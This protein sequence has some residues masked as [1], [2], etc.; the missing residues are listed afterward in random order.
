MTIGS[1]LAPLMPLYCE[2][3]THAPSDPVPDEEPPE[4][5]RAIQLI[6]NLP[7]DPDLAPGWHAAL[8]ASASA[9]AALC[10]D[11]RAEPEGAWFDA[12]HS[13]SQG[14]IRKVTRRA[15][16]AH[17][18]A[19]QDFAGVGVVHG[20]THVRALVP[21]LVQELD[22]RVAKL[23]VGGTDFPVNDQSVVVRSGEGDGRIVAADGPVVTVHVASGHTAPVMSAGKLMA[24]AGHAGMLTA[25]ALAA[26]DT[27]LARRWFEGG[28]ATRVVR[29]GQ[30]QWAQL[31]QIV[32]D[33]YRAWGDHRLVGVRDAGFTEVVPGTTTA[34]AALCEASA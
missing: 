8:A 33:P 21:G 22:K 13:Y 27:D 23:Q 14:H 25:A 12:V 1:A 9:C 31:S 11:A 2:K 18:Q 6:I 28:C 24:Q 34:I 5:I 26:T 20:A 32:R 3:T 29:S 30:Q 17:W 15:R 16:G 10:L 7:K 19:V 4:R